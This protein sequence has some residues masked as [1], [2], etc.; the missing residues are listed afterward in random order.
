MYDT[1]FEWDPAK[2]E[3]KWRK[4][5]VRFAVAAHVFNYPH[6]LLDAERFVEN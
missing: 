6:A 5:G 3:S 1:K 2:A 4:H